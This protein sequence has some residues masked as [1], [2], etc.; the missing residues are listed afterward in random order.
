MIQI[1]YRILVRMFTL[2]HFLFLN[3]DR[4]LSKF[5]RPNFHMKLSLLFMTQY[6]NRAPIGPIF[7]KQG[8]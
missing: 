1:K 7:V 5:D 4:F 3:R 8:I 6:S 2:S